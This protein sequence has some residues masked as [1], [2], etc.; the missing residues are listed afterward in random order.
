MGTSSLPGNF[1][2][3]PKYTFKAWNALQLDPKNHGAEDWKRAIAILKDRIEGRFLAPADTLIAA[4]DG[5]TEATFGF[6]ILALDFLI[7]E[8]I[9]GFRQ[10]LKNH[11]GQSQALFRSFLGDWPEFVTCIPPGESAAT[12]AD[13]LYKQVAARCIIAERPTSF[14]SGA[15]ATWWFFTMTVASM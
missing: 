14:A 1:K 4:E 9:E 3:S 15:A 11:N 8:T 10:G 2:I 13:H 5:K 7:I 6:A 12:K